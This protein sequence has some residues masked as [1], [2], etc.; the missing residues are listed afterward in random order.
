[1]LLLLLAGQLSGFRFFSVAAVPWLNLPS[2][3]LM[4]LTMGVFYVDQPGAI[5]F[6]SLGLLGMLVA[7]LAFPND[8][9]FSN[10]RGGLWVVATAVASHFATLL[11]VPDFITVMMLIFWRS[12][13]LL[14]LVVGD[15]VEVRDVSG[16]VKKVFSNG[17]GYLL[18]RSGFSQ[19][20]RFFQ[21]R[22]VRDGISPTARCIP[23]SLVRITTADG[24]GSGFRVGNYIVTAAHVVPTDEAKIAWGSNTGVARVVKRCDKDVAFL[25]LPPSMQTL[26]TYKFAKSTE[27]GPIAV[28]GEDSDG[29]MLVAVTE[30]VV[31]DGH[32]TY[33][34]QTR[35]GQSGS[36][37]TTVDGRL[38]AVH[39]AN[40]GFSGGGI[41]ITADDVP[42]PKSPKELALEKKL[43][44]MEAKVKE[45][46]NQS[47]PTQDVVDLVRQAV[48]AEFVVLRK[49]INNMVGSFDQ[50]KG[51]TKRG[52]GRHYRV[53][54]G[55]A[56]RRR[57]FTEQEYK[58]L[59]D[60][61]LTRD[62]IR[63]MAEEILANQDEPDLGSEFDSADDA[64]YPQWSDPDSEYEE[65]TN[66]EWFGQCLECLVPPEPVDTLPQHL[67]DKYSLE[68]YYF[69]KNEIKR[70]GAALS[71]Y[72][73]KL[74]ATV[75]H[76]TYVSGE[77]GVLSWAPGITKEEVLRDLAA[78]WLHIN[79]IVLDHGFIPFEQRKKRP[80]PPKEQRPKNRKRGVRAPPAKDSATGQPSSSP[81]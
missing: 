4:F 41:V 74:K 68:N 50:S 27:D 17:S 22:N 15:K 7:S 73:A 72:Q 75:D 12:W 10:L 70:L 39:C 62:Q 37:V 32:Y 19:I 31:V 49:E 29:V 56:R 36:P 66:K 6:S 57:A 45:L 61:G 8:V 23:N 59:L 44:E 51:K 46:M 21:K 58:D 20:R 9:F 3:C 76:A 81:Q 5:I 47:K 54:R 64:G 16:K 1:M 28:I 43:A 2:T 48:A 14:A 13:V 40:T 52:R 30:G 63:E 67:M 80:S 33:A 53:T 77:D 34:V 24:E 18:Q 35:N 25:S 11:A 69:T 42:A 60:K 78:A 65:E 71:E 79:Q 26:P 38:L 55:G